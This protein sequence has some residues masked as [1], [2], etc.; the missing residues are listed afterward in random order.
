MIDSDKVNI[1]LVDDQPAKLLSYEVILRELGENLIRANSA[2]EA[3]QHLIKT[4][5]AVLLVDVC[6][7]DLDGFQLAKMVR[8]HPRFQSTAII[9]ISAVLMTDLDFLR[10]YECGAVD[11]V[12]VPV[13][14]EVLRAKV[15][16]FAELH[17]KTRQLE[18]LNHHLEL[19]VA[20]RTSELEK[21]TAAVK[22]SEER[23]RLAF[24]AAQMGWWDYDW[25][26]RLVSCS[27]SL[28]DE[29]G[30]A[31][32][33]GTLDLEHFLTGIHADDRQAVRALLDPA[34]ESETRTAE[35]RLVPAGGGTRWLLVKGRIRGEAEAHRFAGVTF[36][37]T[38]RK[39]A[40]ERQLTLVHELD[41]RAKN[42]LAV[43]QSV[44][45]LT[46]AESIAEFLAAA[47][48][49]IRALWRAHSLLSESRWQAVDLGRIVRQEFAPFLVRQNPRIAADGPPVLLSPGSAQSLALAMHELVT[50]S[51]KHGALS[52]SAGTVEMRWKLEPE[53][54]TILW[55]EGGG[56]AVT[57]PTRRGFGTKLIV[58]SIEDQLGGKAGFEWPSVGLRCTLTIPLASIG[59]SKP[60]LEQPAQPRSES[61]AAVTLTGSRVLVVEDEALIAIMMKEELADLGF[62]VVGP[63]STLPQAIAAARDAAIDVAILDLNL[64][65]QSSFDVA[66]ILQARGVPFVFVTGYNA[67]AINPRFSHVPLLEKP[68]DLRALRRL[69]QKDR[70]QPSVSMS[71]AGARA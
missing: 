37:I 22:R 65:K 12:S 47:E 53:M 31:D 7:P 56:P 2:Q 67:G 19:R 35:I 11:Y 64:G 10:G 54:L 38:A 71:V 5:V 27:P 4:D 30:L 36:D 1:L 60:A 63:L 28:A 48:G 50:N 21:S 13:V 43:V 59:A 9:F 20:E 55:T 40:E 33:D 34:G 3:F 26:T 44:L 23:I 68:V 58:A 41:H 17:R 52:S 15:K 42:L 69:F 29:I 6:M 14:P 45:R 25:A 39:L 61:Q 8:E 49:R 57:V 16:V 18:Q 51:V 46:Q 32:G 66:E 70:P 62:D 24:E